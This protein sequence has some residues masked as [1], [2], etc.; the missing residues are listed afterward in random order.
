MTTNGKLFLGFFNIISVTFRV[1]T[2]IV[3]MMLFSTCIKLLVFVMEIKLFKRDSVLHK[4]KKCM[5]MTSF[6]FIITWFVAT[7]LLFSL[8]P[9]LSY[10]EAFY[11]VL[12]DMLTVSYHPIQTPWYDINR[13]PWLFTLSHFLYYV[14]MSLVTSLFKMVVDGVVTKRSG[15]CC[16]ALISNESKTYNVTC[17]KCLVV[18]I[19]LEQIKRMRELRQ[20]VA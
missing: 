13:L 16:M 17:P 18:E 5:A 9:T 4:K 20:S 1:I 10:G 15:I 11:S 14:Q 6:F 2:Y 3:G 8:H 12:C 7:S 19:E